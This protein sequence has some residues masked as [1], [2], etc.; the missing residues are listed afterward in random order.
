MP[1]CPMSA[2][3][4]D[5][6]DP[7]LD[8][9]LCKLLCVLVSSVVEGAGPPFSR[10]IC[11]RASRPSGHSEP[12]YQRSQ[13]RGPGRGSVVV[14]DKVWH[15][16]TEL[17]ACV[18][19]CPSRPDA[20]SPSARRGLAA[21][22]ERRFNLDDAAIEHRTASQPGRCRILSATIFLPYP[23]AKMTSGAAAI[24]A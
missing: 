24:T 19:R 16:M 15:N 11:G 20:G 6:S 17:G 8:D 21:G 23:E 7:A 4:G 2:I 5:E 13:S 12:Y 14:D 9:T 10:S 3:R 22:D 1:S 18:S